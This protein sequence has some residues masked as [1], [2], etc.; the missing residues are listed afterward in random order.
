MEKVLTEVRRPFKMYGN[1]TPELHKRVEKFQGGN[2]SS[3]I[4]N[5]KKIT[6]DQVILDIIQHGLKFRIGDK[7]VTNS[8]FE[9]PRSIDERLIIDGETQKLLQKQVSE[10]VANDT[11]TG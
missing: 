1:D 10:E 5:W 9:H 11:N 6:K 8:F 2:I 4:Y 3:Q 7:P